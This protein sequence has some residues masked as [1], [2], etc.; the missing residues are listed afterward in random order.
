[1][2]KNQHVIKIDNRWGVKDEGNSRLMSIYINTGDVYL[3]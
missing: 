1:M 2:G 3:C